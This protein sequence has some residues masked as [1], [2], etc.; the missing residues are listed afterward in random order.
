MKADWPTHDNEDSP[1]QVCI[2]VLRVRVQH[3]L[4]SWLCS[5]SGTCVFLQPTPRLPVLAR[6][7]EAQYR[8]N[9]FPARHSAAIALLRFRHGLAGEAGA[10]KKPWL[11]SIQ[12]Y[13]ASNGPLEPRH[14]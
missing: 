3:C 11:T 6:V 12:S 4:G 10:Q 8:P 5:A 7:G 14:T 13:Q 2:A 9:A 1:P